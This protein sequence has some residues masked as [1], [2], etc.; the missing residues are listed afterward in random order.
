MHI[1]RA[2]FQRGQPVALELELASDQA[3]PKAARLYYRHTHQAQPWQTAPMPVKSGSAR[4]AIP[5]EYTASAY[6]LEYYFEITD[7]AGRVWLYPGLGATL[8]DQPYF[9]Q[10]PARAAGKHG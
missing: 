7:A 3:P 2:L 8:T 9:V 5:G 4:A 1:P 10:R 6:P